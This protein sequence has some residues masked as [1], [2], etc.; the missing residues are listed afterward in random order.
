MVGQLIRNWWIPVVRGVVG[1][2]FGVLVFAY[3]RTAVTVFVYLFGAYALVDGIIALALSFDVTR[4][5]GWVLL[6]GI[7]GI[8]AGI[9]TFFYPSATAVALVYIV[10]AWAIITGIFEIMAALEWRQVLSDMWMLGLAGVLSIILGVLLFSSPSAGLLAWAYVIG[11]YA[12]L[13]G[14]LYIVAGFR[15][16]SFQPS[17]TASSR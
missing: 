4:G 3:P 12:I 14:V 7:A 6:S 2:L 10:A 13:Y 15:L 1:I 8:A 9:L 17:Q 5:R 16:K 11:F